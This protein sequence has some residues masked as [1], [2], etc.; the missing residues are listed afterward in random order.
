MRIA[1]ISNRPADQSVAA[2]IA[3]SLGMEYAVYPSADALVAAESK[4]QASVATDARLSMSVGAMSGNGSVGE[5]HNSNGLASPAAEV[6]PTATAPYCVVFEAPLDMV[7]SGQQID[8]VLDACPGSPVI[9]VCD[10]PS[11]ELA[12][13]AMRRGMSNILFLDQPTDQLSAALQE[14]V[15]AGARATAFAAEKKELQA[16]ATRLTDAE[17]DVLE[18]MLVGLANKQ[19]AQ[20]LQIGLRTVELRRSKIMRKMDAKSLAELVKFICIARELGSPEGAA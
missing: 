13:A 8:S 4:A 12:V 3:N 7:L 20:S 14:M 17:E 19:I 1:V 18:A 10:R 2:G 11:A 5:A 9:A 6:V 16:R 15:S